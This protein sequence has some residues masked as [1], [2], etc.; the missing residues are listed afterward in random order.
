[1]RPTLSQ[2]DVQKLVV[3]PS[4]ENRADTA[5][6][7]AANYSVEAFSEDERAIAEDIFRLMV[8]DTAVR[9][10]EA[11]SAELKD[12]PTLTRD[13]ALSL[14]RDVETV[15]LPI[16]QSSTALTDDDLVELVRTSAPVKQKA[17]ASRPVVSA[18]VADALVETNDEEVVSTLVANEGAEISEVSLQKVVDTFGD[19]PTVNQPLALRQKLPVSVA[20]RLVTLVSETLR[21]H[22]LKRPDIS[23]DVIGDLVVQ[24]RERATLSLISAHASLNEV[25]ALVEQLHRNARLTPSIVLRSLCMGDLPFFEF[26]LSTLSHV[27]IRNA[28]VLIHDDGPLGLRAIM[29]K[30]QI[31]DYLQPAFR[32]AVDVIHETDYDGG[33]HDQERFKRRM[34]E[35]ILTHFEDPRVG[36]GDADL[37]YL[38]SKLSKIDAGFSLRG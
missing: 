2:A 19:R 14:A 28:R 33:D 24:S 8:R 13:V 21:D 4:V 11:L 31:P 10:R 25:Q 23:P 3:D 9:V 30:A 7:I 22:L 6:K 27:P 26:G 16:L 18:P 34:L 38:V 12:C 35:R 1:M 20:E 36:F 5:A 29:R 17:I 15:A 37:E 32:A